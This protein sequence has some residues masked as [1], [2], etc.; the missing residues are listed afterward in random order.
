MATAV[1]YDPNTSV[2]AARTQYFTDNAFGDDGGYT[3]KWVILGTL[4]PLKIGFP[5]TAARIRAV[6]LH[7]IHHLVTNYDTTL[8]GEAEIAAW[9]LAS[10]CARFPAAVVLNH[11][12]LPIGLLRDPDRVRRAFARGCSSKNLYDKDFDPAVLDEQLGD[13]RERLGVGPAAHV[14]MTPAQRWRWRRTGALALLTWL[15]V[16][17][18][19][20][21]FALALVWL[22]WLVWAAWL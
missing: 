6:Q 12:A 13:L 1:E 14:E 17:G 3:S 5:N 18:T 4:G 2:L 19:L 10:G 22:V 15:A 21:A 11:L 20:A 8:V 9:E 7:D 16:L